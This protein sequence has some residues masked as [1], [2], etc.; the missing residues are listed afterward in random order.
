MQAWL[1]VLPLLMAL[2]LPTGTALS[3]LVDWHMLGPLGD[4]TGLP[5]LLC[6]LCCHSCVST[7][8]APD[9]CC[10]FGI[11]KGHRWATGGCLLKAK[12]WGPEQV[13]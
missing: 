3:H 13:L 7:S 10:S 6:V 12:D 8:H 4:R 9:E 2:N 1:P 5:P 11:D